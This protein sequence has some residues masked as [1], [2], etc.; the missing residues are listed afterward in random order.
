[1]VALKEYNRSNTQKGFV[2][3]VLVSV[4]GNHLD[5]GVGQ[6]W[7]QNG[8]DTKEGPQICI[9]LRYSGPSIGRH[10]AVGCR[11]MMQMGNR[12]NL[13]FLEQT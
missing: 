9:N 5:M 3:E 4:A 6:S 11:S 2:W 8:M 12:L 13:P 10:P 1:M 7:Y